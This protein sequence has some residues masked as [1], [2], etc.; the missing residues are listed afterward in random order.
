MSSEFLE[1][2][3]PSGIVTTEHIPD[4]ASGCETSER[5]AREGAEII[6][7]IR[8][9]DFLILLRDDGKEL[10]SGAFASYLSRAITDAAGRVVFVIGGAWGVSDSVKQR[11]DDCLSMSRMTFTHEMCFLFLTEQIYR[12][13]SIL[14]GSGY[15]H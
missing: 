14:G 11:A 9:R 4:V 15:H 1:R 5:T 8:D 6:R 3:R 12:A 10:N 7:R 13:F 2:V